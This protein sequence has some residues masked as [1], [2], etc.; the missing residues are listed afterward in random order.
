M[1][2]C[3]SCTIKKAEHWR[4]DVFWTVVLEKTPESPLDSKVQSSFLKE[5]S[6]ECSLE[7]WCWSWNSNT[8]ATWCEEVTHLKTPWCWE[9]FKVEEEGDNRGWDGWM[10]SLTQWTWVWVS[11]GSGWWTGKFGFLQSMGLQR[12]GYYWET[13]L[14]WT[15]VHV[16]MANNRHWYS[17]FK[18]EFTLNSI[19]PKHKK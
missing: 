8:L 17:Q 2:E 5:S 15:E 1:Y 14:N 18:N 3:A 10:A 9:R 16:V 13:E 12:V 4:I 11:S 7:D 6:P 19:F